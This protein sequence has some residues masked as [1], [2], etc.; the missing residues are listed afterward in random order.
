MQELNVGT[1]TKSHTMEGSVW[2]NDN[3]RFIACIHTMEGS[4]WPNHNCRFIEAFSYMTIN[5]CCFVKNSFSCNNDT[6]GSDFSGNGMTY[7]IANHT[8]RQTSTTTEF[9]YFMTQLRSIKR[10]LKMLVPCNSTVYLNSFITNE[11]GW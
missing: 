9:I 8:P 4:V 11:G 10:A 2:P 3:Y 6:T 5:T 1:V 7:A